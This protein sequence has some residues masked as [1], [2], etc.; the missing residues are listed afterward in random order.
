MNYPGCLVSIVLLTCL[1]SSN[2]IAQPAPASIKVATIEGL[3]RDSAG[4]C[5]AQAKVYARGGDPF[6]TVETATDSRG[7]FMVHLRIAGTYA[8]AVEKQGFQHHDE[9]SVAIA[10]DT[11]R[12]LE[13][14]LAPLP[15]TANKSSASSGEIQF[16]DD[17]NF[18]VAGITDWTAAGGHGSDTNLR[19]SEVLARD[20]SQLK[21]EEISGLT[22]KSSEQEL[23]AAVLRNPSSP[24]ANREL[25]EFYLRAQNE[26]R[27]ILPLQTAHKLRPDDYASAYDLVLAYEGIG[28]LT[29]ARK[30]VES[31]LQ[32]ND[33]ADMH[34]LLGDINEQ[35]N[36]PVA[37]E[38]QYERATKIDPSEQNYFAWGVEL[39]IHRAIKPAVEVFSTGAHAHP[40]SARMLEGLGAALYASGLY[41]EAARKLCAASDLEPADSTAYLFIGEIA[42]SSN[43]PLPCVG[44][45]LARFVHNQ[46]N[47]A[48]GNFYYAVSLWKRRTPVRDSDSQRVESLLR[49]AVAVDP[50]LAPAYVQL[51]IVYSAHGDLDN[52]RVA[53]D[54]AIAIDPDLPEAHFRLGQTY[55]RLGNLPKANEQFQAFEQITKNDAAAVEKKRREVRQFVIVLKNQSEPSSG[56]RP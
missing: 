40:E 12:Y 31:I 44:D 11:S 38:R 18:V 17:N 27:A 51:G 8:I 39:L 7:K 22:N 37:A 28:A 49:N 33:R 9:A 43:E 55:K 50:K 25:G 20:T 6:E 10:L 1:G 42:Q 13:F 24:E 16:A 41:E 4:N 53:F 26:H 54:E 15:Q 32:M 47:S 21:R 29:P 35:M 45:K 48:L 36:D 46:P 34:R 23:K 3:V 2:G 56:P 19:A 30:L 5:I 52:A 14:V